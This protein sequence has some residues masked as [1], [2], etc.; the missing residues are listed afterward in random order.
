MTSWAGTE[1][2]R[3]RMAGTQTR[4]S[5][6][7]DVIS[8]VADAGESVLRGLF[9]LPRRVV[10]GTLDEASHLL[11]GAATKLG[12]V[13][14]LDSRVSALEKRLDSLEKPA[15]TRSS[16]STRAQPAER[17][18]EPEAARAKDE[19]KSAQ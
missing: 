10:A 6:D 12:K 3:L 4:T 13:D 1:R 5:R 19:G 11:H 7:K 8:R 2:Y 17:R 9:S 16:A 14:P 18:R 15:A